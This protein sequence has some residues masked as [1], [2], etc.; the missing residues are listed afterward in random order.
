M[1]GGKFWSRNTRSAKLTVGQVSEIRARYKS[2]L[3]TQGRLA[4]E[5]GISVVQI[6][7][8]VRNEVWQILPPEPPTSAELDA[9]AKRLLAFQES[10]AVDRMAEDIKREKERSQAGDK[11]LSEIIGEPNDK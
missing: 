2:G 6:G 3:I 4:N 7:R 8:I 11:M 5:Y 1:T 10:L 9:S